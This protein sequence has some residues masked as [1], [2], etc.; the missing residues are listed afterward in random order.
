MSLLTAPILKNSHILAGIYF[1]FL[2]NF[3][4]Q[5][6][7]SFNTK[8]RPQ[9]KDQKSSYQVKQILELLCN[10]FALILGKNCVKDRRVTKIDHEIKFEGV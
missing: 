10:L 8:F 3:L 9:C 5:T 7:K 1:I 4:K 6:W 2:K